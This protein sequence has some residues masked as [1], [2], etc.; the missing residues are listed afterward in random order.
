MLCTPSLTETQPGRGSQC[1]SFSGHPHTP[2]SPTPTASLQLPRSLRLFPSLGL[3]TLPLTLCISISI[4]LYLDHS[5]LPRLPGV[6]SSPASF[7]RRPSPHCGAT[8][9][10]ADPEWTQRPRTTPTPLPLRPHPLRPLSVCLGSFPRCF[11][12]CSPSSL[13]S[14]PP[15][16]LLSLL[17][18]LLHIFPS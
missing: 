1:R 2:H 4:S 12:L 17:S 8:S 15:L 9:H 18:W 5:P 10:P 14:H 7:S 16:Y 6:N 13:T 3:V 11:L